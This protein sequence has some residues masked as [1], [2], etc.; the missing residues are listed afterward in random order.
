MTLFG[1]YKIMAQN[2]KGTKKA[3]SDEL[4]S[5]CPP[6]VPFL[7]GNCH[8]SHVSFQYS[9]NTA[10]FVSLPYSSSLLVSHDGI[11]LFMLF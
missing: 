2:A 5:N 1:Q 4:Q 8:V 7:R 9:K 10:S 3:Y 6:T 11:I